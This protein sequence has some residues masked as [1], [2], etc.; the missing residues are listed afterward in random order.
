MK[1]LRSLSLAAIAALLSLGLQARPTDPNH[2]IVGTWTFTEPNSGCTEVYKFSSSGISKVTSADE[3][4]ESE[5][6]IADSPTANGFYAWSE[7]VT[8][9]NGLKDCGGNVTEIGHG[10]KYFVVFHSSGDMF[11]VCEK[12][13]LATCM[14]PFKRRGESDA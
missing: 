7:K 1:P 4:V 10:V 12:E 3:E 11:L 9:G 5:F 14:G 8:K 13:D 2:L 6:D